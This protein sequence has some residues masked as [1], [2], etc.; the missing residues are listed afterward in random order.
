MPFADIALVRA[1]GWP[2]DLGLYALSFAIGE[3]FG[4]DQSPEYVLPWLQREDLHA[5]LAWIA[6]GPWFSWGLRV[7]TWRI[8]KLLGIMV[9][10]LWV[11]R[12]LA[13]GTLAR[14]AQGPMEALWRRLTYGPAPAAAG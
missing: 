9:L 6:S 2:P 14:H 12:R 8:P 10:G 4:I 5:W 3:R 7:E 11:G 13:A 1:L